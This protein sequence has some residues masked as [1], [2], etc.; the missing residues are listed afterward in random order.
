MGSDLWVQTQLFVVK[1]YADLWGQTQLF[2][3]KIYGGK[4]EL[5]AV[6]TDDMILTIRC[7]AVLRQGL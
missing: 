3:V 7:Q 5:A 4:T 1:V 6:K 2:V